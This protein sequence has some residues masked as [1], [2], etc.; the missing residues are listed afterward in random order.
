MKFIIFEIGFFSFNLHV[1]YL[2]LGFIASYCAF[3]LLTR[4]FNLPTRGFELLTLGFE[5]VT[6][7]FELVTRGFEHVTCGLVTRKL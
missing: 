7:G 4:T 2:T 5:L 1:Y 3:N 6:H